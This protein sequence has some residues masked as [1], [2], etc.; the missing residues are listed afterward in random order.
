VEPDVLIEF[1]ELDHLRTLKTILAS[2]ST[3]F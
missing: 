1:A 3:L 2:F